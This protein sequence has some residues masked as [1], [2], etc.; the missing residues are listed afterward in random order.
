METENTNSRAMNIKI[1]NAS[2]AVT[3]SPE[4]VRL[5]VDF[6]GE[7]EGRTIS[8]VDILIV[9]SREM[10]QMNRSYL[11]H[12]GATDVITFD[13]SDSSEKGIAVQ[14]IICDEVA[15]MQAGD[16]GLTYV[17]EL[18][19]YI[20]HG[21]LHTMG[22]DDTTPEEFEKMQIRQKTLLDEFLAENPVG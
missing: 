12:E 19:T 3:V 2:Q 14:L 5:L 13:L 17:Q 9:E 10:A 7:K 11:N 8:E 22:Y 18:L 6:V 21:L 15:I 4:A 1:E 16:H 20:I